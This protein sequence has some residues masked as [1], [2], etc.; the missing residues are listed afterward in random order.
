MRRGY[1]IHG[2]EFKYLQ[3]TVTKSHLNLS[4]TNVIQC[5][6]VKSKFKYLVI[7]VVSTKPKYVSCILNLHFSISGTRSTILGMTCY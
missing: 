3:L 6:V 4:F 1:K 7:I 5:C 2:S